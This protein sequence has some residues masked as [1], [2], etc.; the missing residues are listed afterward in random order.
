MAEGLRLAV[1]RLVA[2]AYRRARCRDA[3]GAITRGRGRAAFAVA[4]GAAVRGA[5]EQRWRARCWRRW[6]RMKV[7]GRCWV[8]RCAWRRLARHRQP[9]PFSRSD[10]IRANPCGGVDAEASEHRVDLV[11]VSRD[12]GGG[13][14]K[15]ALAAVRT[16]LAE[17]DLEMEG[18]RCV[19]LV[20]LFADATR[21]RVGLWRALL[22]VKAGG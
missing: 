2:H 6:P 21:Q 8:I 3:G 11:V 9:I 18:W 14:A 17:A 13:Q 12:L 10:D 1:K 15:D 7:S 4:A 16:A 22:R 5:G 19:L 20:P